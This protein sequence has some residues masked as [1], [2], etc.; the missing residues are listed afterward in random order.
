MYLYLPSGLKIKKGKPEA[1]IRPF[2]F[3]FMLKW[4]VVTVCNVLHSETPAARHLLKTGVFFP[5]RFHVASFSWSLFAACSVVQEP[6]Q[7][8]TWCFTHSRSEKSLWNR[9]LYQLPV[10]FL[11]TGRCCTWRQPVLLLIAQQDRTYSCLNTKVLWNF[12]RFLFPQ[13]KWE[14]RRNQ[15]E[16]DQDDQNPICRTSR[17]ICLFG[18][19][20]ADH[21]TSTHF[22]TNSDNCVCEK[23]RKTVHFKMHWKK[24]NLC[25]PHKNLVWIR[26]EKEFFFLP[27]CLRK[28]LSD[29]LWIWHFLQFLT[30]TNTSNIQKQTCF[31]FRILCGSSAWMISGELRSD[32]INFYLVF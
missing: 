9:K 1:S 5:N 31:I 18:F 27:P 16:L 20:R 3:S 7:N 28:T 17:V 23:W 25:F 11:P 8:K 22:N 2:T 15:N 19:R 10:L 26:I 24:E 4:R 14:G 29:P 12:L 21:L 30:V 32:H 6:E 13:N